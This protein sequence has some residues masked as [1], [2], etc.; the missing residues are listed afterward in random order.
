MHAIS[1]RGVELLI[2]DSS[3]RSFGLS[4]VV[5]EGN[6]ITANAKM[7][8]YKCYVARWGT[9]DDPMN[10]KC[11]LSTIRDG[12]NTR[13]VLFYMQT[14]DKR[15]QGRTSRDRLEPPFSKCTMLRAKNEEYI[16][17]E[18]RRF[19]GDIGSFESLVDLID[20]PNDEP[21]IRLQ[22][23]FKTH[24]KQSPKKS[25]SI[26][27]PKRSPIIRTGR[28]Q[29]NFSLRRPEPRYDPESDSENDSNAKDDANDCLRQ[30]QLALK[31]A[32][33]EEKEVLDAVEAKLAA[34]KK[35]TAS[36]RQLL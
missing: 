1:H 14:K 25:S 3:H 19:R 27:S 31:S 34:T 20:G 5:A 17:L 18:I 8:E 29:V 2:E 33:K 12:R 22:I 15:T 26:S 24:P 7:E 28:K 16:R 35:R 21:Y 13:A 6:T 30:L 32:E 10:V 11:E 9:T 4:D 36:L 23:T